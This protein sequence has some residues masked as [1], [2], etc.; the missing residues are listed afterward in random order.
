MSRHVN[1]AFVRAFMNG[2]V[3]AEDATR[4]L[5]DH[6]SQ[7]C[8][9]C[10]Q[11]LVE[12]AE[13]MGLEDLQGQPRLPGTTLLRVLEKDRAEQERGAKSLAALLEQ[14]GYHAPHLVRAGPT[15]EFANPV[16]AQVLLSRAWAACVERNPNALALAKATTEVGLK[17]AKVKPLHEMSFEFR[18][19]GLVVT[20]NAQRITDQLSAALTTLEE[21]GELLQDVPDPGILCD[22]FAILGSVHLDSGR[23]REAEVAFSE[24][25]GLA[26]EAGDNERAA[27]VC[28]KVS[29]LFQLRGD[30]KHA[31]TAL[32]EAVAALGEGNVAA[33]LEMFASA[34]L[35][36]LWC[37]L[38]VPAAAEKELAKLDPNEVAKLGQ[39]PKLHWIRGKVAAARDAS[40]EAL[41]ELRQAARLFEADEFLLESG[42]VLLDI[43][44]I[45]F[46]EG[47]SQ[48]LLETG[49]SLGRLSGLATDEWVASQLYTFCLALQSD[50]LTRELI[51]QLYELLRRRA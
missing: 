32:Q 18:L 41:H 19:A 30:R 3:S 47:D 13:A 24:A 36:L 50:T 39:K 38:G 27:K 40:D 51:Q 48:L 9:E 4:V 35:A 20:A 33:H 10:R 16:L 5:M 12:E 1:R 17:L 22:Y 23:D 42:L 11:A 44:K 29:D 45:A 26:A 14:A 28:M 34:N 31:V 37:E 46:D 43:A 6:L 15:K 8:P 2:E 21:A 7:Q 25:L 49:L